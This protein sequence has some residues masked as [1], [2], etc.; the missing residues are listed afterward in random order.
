MDHTKKIM[1]VNFK[2]N[3]PLSSHTSI[4]LGGN[5]DYFSEC[6]DLD[7]IIETLIFAKKNNLK[8]QVMSGGSN[9]IFPDSGYKGIVLKVNNKGVNFE[10]E[11]DHS[12]ITVSAGENWDDLVKLCI[13][14]DLTGVECMS[15]I[16]GSVGAAPVQN[17][18][19]YG[20]EVKNTIQSLKALDKKNITLVEFSNE[21]CKFAYRQSR[22]KAEDAERYIITEVTFSLKKSED[23]QIYYP[24]LQNFLDK[25]TDYAVLKTTKDKLLK[26]RKSVMSL[27]KKKS[28]VLDKNDPNSRSCGSFFINPIL[29]EDDFIDIKSKFGSIPYYKTEFY[30]KIPAAW[31][32]EQA[33]F[34]KGYK[35]GRAGIS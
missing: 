2:N 35:F 30:F 3:I 27:R 16:P 20:Q 25:N 6:F 13:E 34:Y 4:E 7:S 33:G 18:G 21:E 26:I 17:I 29:N 22:F 31:L 23:P 15:G 12:K 24:E 28:M 14:N 9:I 32:I 8:V 19:A 11:A 10:N 5:A 1:P